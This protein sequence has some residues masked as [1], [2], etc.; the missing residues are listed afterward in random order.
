MKRKMQVS[1][2]G[3][4]TSAYMAWWLKN[5]MAEEY[6]MHFV[7]ANT[8]QEHPDTYRFLAACDAAF[9]LGLALVECVV[10]A[11]RKGST[12]K[13]VSHE[14][15]NRTGSP[16]E[17]EIRKY[18]ISNA[19]FIHCTREMKVNP[20]RSY[21][22]SIW[23]DEDYEIAI[24]IRPDETRRV[25]K[26]AAEQKIVYPLIDMHLRYPDLPDKDFIVDW[27]TQFSWDLRIPEYLGNCVTCHK[28]SDKKLNMVFRDD[29]EHFAFFASMEAQYGHIKPVMDPTPGDRCWWRQ[30]RTTAQLLGGFAAADVDT[31][32]QFSDES[33]GCDESCEPYEMEESDQ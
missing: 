12:H 24:G 31:S 6:D 3:G 11:G 23:P 33:G 15:A 17:A 10:H 13:I 2:S 19:T 29:P 8:G 4:R 18:G 20:M 28:K 27:F 14:T 16:F 30:Y 32:R 22:R 25:S 1:V 26:N 21:A 7:F 9:D 5:N